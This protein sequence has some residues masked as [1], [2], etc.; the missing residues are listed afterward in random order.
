MTAVRRHMIVKMCQR[1]SE[2]AYS[3]LQVQ[4]SKKNCEE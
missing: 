1:P 4:P 2:A 3:I